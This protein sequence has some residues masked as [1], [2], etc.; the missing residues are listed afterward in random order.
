[1]DL[2][3]WLLTP[4]VSCGPDA[5][6]SWLQRAVGLHAG[7]NKSRQ[8]GGL[9]T[10]G[11]RVREATMQGPNRYGWLPMVFTAT[12]VPSAWADPVTVSSAVRNGEII[13]RTGFSIAGTV[14][15]QGTR[16]VTVDL[17]FE[18]GSSPALCQPCVPGEEISLSSHIVAPF[19]GQVR[20][21][22]DQ[23]E[24]AGFDSGGE[25]SLQAPSFTL[26]VSPAGDVTFRS[27]MTFTGWLF[28]DTQ[29]RVSFDL[30]GAGLVT[31]VFNVFPYEHE[32]GVQTYT[33]KSLHYDF[34]PAPVPEPATV[35]LL[36]TGVL[37][38]G[39]RAFRSRRLRDG[40]VVRT[41][42]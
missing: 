14:D 18:S 21:R 39:R 28:S 36:A 4:A 40:S 38:V 41:Q 32:L 12:L 31:G 15:L 16:G 19:S 37:A 24:H 3:M 13:L 42:L 22:G 26:P 8:R 27:P 20:Y 23:F 35:L 5:V 17:T 1:M 25:M 30:S 2:S 33:L 11:N 7:H 9:W 10:S 34:T 6:A 29:P